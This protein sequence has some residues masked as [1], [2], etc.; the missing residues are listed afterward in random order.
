MKIGKISGRKLYTAEE[1][2]KMD[3]YK[4][5]GKLAR[6]IKK[7]EEEYEAQQK[8]NKERDKCRKRKKKSPKAQE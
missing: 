8:K 5:T 4:I 1:Y 2:L 3:E 7:I 6:D